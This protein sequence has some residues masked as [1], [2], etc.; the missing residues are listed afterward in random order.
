MALTLYSENYHLVTTAMDGH[1]PSLGGSPAK[2]K[3]G[4]PKKRRKCTT[5]MEFGSYT[6]L[7][8]L[9]PGDN[10]HASSPTILRMVTYHP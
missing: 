8:K 5:D 3:D 10:C 4:H 6:L 9:A 1:P 7:T 2:P